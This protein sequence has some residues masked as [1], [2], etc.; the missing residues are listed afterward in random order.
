MKVYISADMEGIAGIAH[1]D[2]TD[3][4]HPEYGVFCEQMT[5]EVA[6]ACQGA[7]EAEAD[8]VWIKDA[9]E[10]GRNLIAARL[11]RDAVLIRG[12]SGHPFSMVQELDDTFD[13][14]IL[15]GYHSP[16]GSDGDPL[17]HT[18]SRR[19]SWMRINDQ[20]CS[21]MWLAAL[22]A[23]LVDVPAVF[24]SGDAYTCA[25]VERLIPGVRTV[26]VK[27]G[28]G[29]SASSIS[30]EMAVEKIRE[31]VKESLS[32][33]RDGSSISLPDHLHVEIKYRD[34]ADAFRNS[35]FP[36][37]ALS[38]PNIITYE[39]EVFFDVLTFISFV[40]G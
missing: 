27:R 23:G 22:T 8:E 2:E 26:P 19:I 12:W 14:L 18:I 24:V 1:W 20:L 5:K 6:A 16:G 3:K 34:H 33:P 7:V 10:S 35:Y 28:A 15:I 21:E 17:A 37:A 40:V 29:N 36:G 32:L 13:A 4:K 38:G 11:P 30:P 9:H 39:G 31:G 25:E